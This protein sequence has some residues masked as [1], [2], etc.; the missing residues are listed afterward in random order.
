MALEPSITFE[1][2]DNFFFKFDQN[3]RLIY[4]HVCCEGLSRLQIIFEV[5]GQKM[6]KIGHFGLK[7]PFLALELSITFEDG[8]NFF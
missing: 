4:I 1:D 6:P 2:G 8:D 5:I 7:W 3:K